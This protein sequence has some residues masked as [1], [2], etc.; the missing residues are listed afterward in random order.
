MNNLRWLCLQE[1]MIEKLLNNLFNCCHLQVLHLTKCNRLQF[2]FDI[3]GHGPNMSISIDM[4][5]LSTPIGNLSALLELNLSGCLSLQELP[6][7]I[8]QL[9]VLEN[10]NLNTSSSL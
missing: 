1:C 3:L 7:S 8:G 10:L 6:I 4:K 2:V 5:D 9:S